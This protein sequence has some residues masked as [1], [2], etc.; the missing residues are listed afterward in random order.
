MGKLV[1][2]KEEEAPRAK[3]PFYGMMGFSKALVGNGENTCA[4]SFKNAPC[5]RA[6]DGE[7]PFW[8]SCE[9]FNHS[10]NEKVIEKILNTFYV[11]PLETQ[12]PGG[13]W[14]G[15]SAREWFNRIMAV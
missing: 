13:S 12:K 14:E 2:P 1:L 8:N 11:F 3:C 4:L 5:F 10:S 15:V 9:R 6:M 7:A